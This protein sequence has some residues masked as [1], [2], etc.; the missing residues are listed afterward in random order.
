[1]DLALE[2]GMSLRHL[3]YIETGRSQPG[4]DRVAAIAD[5]LDLP[6]RERNELLIAAGY[7]PTFPESPLEAP[8]MDLVRSAASAILAQHDPLPAFAFDRRWDLIE[9]ND[10]MRRL[11]QALRPGGPVHNNILL[12]IFDPDDMRPVIANWSEVA[13]ELLRHLHHEVRRFPTDGR[14]RSL[15]AQVT[16]FPDVPEDW[17]RRQP[18]NAPL[19]VVT[20]SF[21][22]RGERLNFF[23]TLTTFVG[24]FDVVADELRIESMHPVDESTRAFCLSL[25]PGSAPD[26]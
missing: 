14:L 8:Q 2:A 20:T 1:M 24:A 26:R 4:R 22:S 10:G 5:V 18:G 12:Q 15:L 17:K 13:C 25:A 9:P 23:S 21:I 3:S 19:P 11:L 6:L 7:A 16:A